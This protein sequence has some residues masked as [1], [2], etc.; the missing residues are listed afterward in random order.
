MF[1]NSRSHVIAQGAT[2]Y[3]IWA[4]FGPVGNTEKRYWAVNEKL[5]KA[6]C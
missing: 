2:E 5:F 3:E 4:D 1:E 6:V